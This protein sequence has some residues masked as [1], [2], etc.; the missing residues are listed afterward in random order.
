VQPFCSGKAISVTYTACEFAAF[1]IQN[2]M[3]MRRFFSLA[4]P[5]VQYFFTL[6]HK[7][8]DFRKKVNKCETCVFIYLQLLSGK[9]SDSKKKLGEI[10]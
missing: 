3:R 2:V 10:G 8:H 9:I 4:R 7:R 5:A 1:G 6:S